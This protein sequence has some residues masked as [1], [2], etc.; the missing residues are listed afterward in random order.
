MKRVVII[1]LFCMMFFFLF[2]PVNAKGIVGNSHFLNFSHSIYLL[3]EEEEEFNGISNV[4]DSGIDMSKYNQ[5][6]N[7]ESLLGDPTVEDSVA[8][9][10][11]KALNIVKIVGPLLVVVL[12]SIDF[13]KVIINGDDDA[14]TKAGKKL[15][16]RLVLA[17]ALFFIPTLVIV[18]LDV[19]GIMGD[20]TCGIQ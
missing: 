18:L 13:A 9:L 4:D 19:F 8:W 11:Q 16:I 5:E 3:D 14:M 15:G 7:C 12:S 1:F 2:T 20:P 17:A 6:Q 10:L